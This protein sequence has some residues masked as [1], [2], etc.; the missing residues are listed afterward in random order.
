MY[1]YISLIL[2]YLNKIFLLGLI[3][4]FVCLFVFWGGGGLGGV[5]FLRGGGGVNIQDVA[6]S[7]TTNQ[8]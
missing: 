7:V 4:F 1:M 2:I 3:E 5:L 8:P 6:V